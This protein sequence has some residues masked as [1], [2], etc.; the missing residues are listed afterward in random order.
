MSTGRA[1]LTCYIELNVSL[2]GS[3]AREAEEATALH[4]NE[5]LSEVEN[6]M[7][8]KQFLHFVLAMLIYLLFFLLPR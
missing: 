8:G 5:F 2:E 3:N 6:N 7:A 1:K 4:W